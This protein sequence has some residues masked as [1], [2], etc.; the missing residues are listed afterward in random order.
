MKSP[1]EIY[2]NLLSNIKET[3]PI[4]EEIKD[5]VVGL[6]ALKFPTQ[7]SCAGHLDKPWTYPYVDIYCDENFADDYSEE[8]IKAKLKWIKNNIKLQNKLIPL[9]KEFH[10]KNKIKFQYQITPHTSIDLA[11]IRL[12]SINADTLQILTKT[13]RA[14]ELKKL[15]HLTN[16]LAKFLL[17][18]Y[19]K[20]QI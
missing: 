11:V 8:S 12:K 20:N 3:T 10:E 9:L 19:R 13:E 16:K 18:K 1:D 17:E 7:N 15:Q 2:E 5:L 4:D 14:K 6:N